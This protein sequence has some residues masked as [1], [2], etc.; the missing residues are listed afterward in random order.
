MEPFTVFLAEVSKDEFGLST[1]S[2][3]LKKLGV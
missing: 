2:W 3:K 1:N